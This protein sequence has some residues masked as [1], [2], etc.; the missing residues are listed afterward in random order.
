MNKKNSLYKIRSKISHDVFYTSEKFPMKE[1][2]GQIFIGVIKS[3]DDKNIFYMK[4]DG[5]EKC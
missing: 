1:I 4:K 2:D 5:I 3:K